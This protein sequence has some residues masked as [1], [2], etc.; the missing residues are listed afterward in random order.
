M[1]IIDVILIIVIGI[2]IYSGWKR[3]FIESALELSIW[4]GS[5][6]LAFFISV[7]IVHVLQSISLSGIWIR[8]VAF[9]ILLIFFSQLITKTGEGLT[10]G[11]DDELH[12]HWGNKLLGVI[13]G[14]VSGIVYSSLISFFAL[15][16][17]LGNLSQRTKDSYLA[18]LLNH[19]N[20]W[21]GMLL[22]E[23]AA[24]IG[25]RS[26]E[27]FTVHTKGAEL[28]S[29]PFRTKEFRPRPD[30]EKRMLELIN[31]ERRK[32]NLSP[33]T[34]DKKLAQVATKH[35]SDMLQ[36]GY[37]SHYT[38]EGLGPFDR[39]RKDRVRFRI[40]GENLALA[41]TLQSA[42]QGFME[43]PV[44]KANILHESFGRAGIGILDA[45][46]NGIMVTQNFRN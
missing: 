26:P 34:F 46:A 20:G 12:D 7:L 37:F 28:V 8:P 9:I 14:L 43:S 11:L 2:S 23:M 42:H 35:S 30:L 24:D 13:P 29:L 32:V 6:L 41:Q 40:A 4:L 18:N 39:L 44:H 19:K 17:P 45:G 25:Y 36:R 33:M 22:S 31:I 5:F 27:N 21:P 15:S 10:K 16:Y 38:P 3:G 1:N